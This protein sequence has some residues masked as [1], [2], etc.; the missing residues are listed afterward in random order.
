MNESSNFYLNPNWHPMGTLRMGRNENEG[1]CDENLEV[2]NNPGL[3]LLNAGVFPS[4]SN[5][6][7]TSMVM[8]LGEK[9]GERLLK[10]K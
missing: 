10:L 2:F 6:N 4:G 8:A 1:V 7:P 9:L 3:F 5:Q